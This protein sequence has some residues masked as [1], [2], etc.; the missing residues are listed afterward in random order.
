MTQVPA[1]PREEDVEDCLHAS[2][3]DPCIT[4]KVDDMQVKAKHDRPLYLSL[5]HI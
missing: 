1:G 2:Q 5:I 4:F 3:N